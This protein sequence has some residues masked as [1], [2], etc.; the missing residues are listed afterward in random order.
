MGLTFVMWTNSKNSFFLFSLQHFIGS[1][2]K[3]VPTQVLT[4]PNIA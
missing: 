3:N 4:K 1:S 2:D